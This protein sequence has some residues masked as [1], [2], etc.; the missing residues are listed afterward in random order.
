MLHVLYRLRYLMICHLKAIG[1]GKLLVQ[2]QFNPKCLR[3]KRGDGVNVS[4]SAEKTNALAHP[5]RQKTNYFFFPLSFCLFHSQQIGWYAPH[6]EGQSALLSLHIE[7]LIL[8]RHIL[9][10]IPKI[11]F[12]HISEHFVS[13]SNGHK[14]N[15]HIPL[16]L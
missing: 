12:S 4:L 11:V 5:V 6:Q 10:A 16:G 7:M 13:W 2:F 14:I 1:T 8:P 15:H 9:S 3:I